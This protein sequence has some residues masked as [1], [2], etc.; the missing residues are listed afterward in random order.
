MHNASLFEFLHNYP[1][2]SS[3]EVRGEQAVF[4]NG[5]QYVDL[6]DVVQM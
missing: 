1:K 4:N 5:R 6:E 3:L 2:P